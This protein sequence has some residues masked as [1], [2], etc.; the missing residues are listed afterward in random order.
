MRRTIGGLPRRQERRS[1]GRGVALAAVIAMAWTWPLRAAAPSGFSGSLRPAER[2][3]LGL[4]KLTPAELAGLDAAVE[5]YR[6]AGEAAAARDAA[7]TAVAD[8]QR[9]E[10]P[11][12]VAR[13]MAQARREQA[14][15]QT[16]RIEA[17]VVG[18]FTG[19]NGRTVF[20]LDNGQVWR[21]VDP[22][23]YY[24]SPQQ[25]TP[26]EIVRSRYGSY[27]LHLKNGA[28]VTVARLR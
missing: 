25:N 3:V 11:K 28:W 17:V 22:D 10:E 2:A 27:R 4:D 16:E 24:T 21:Q 7:Q 19:W 23:V 1:S 15:S 26:V 5:A 9:R 18:P 20:E 12:R 13:A 6:H 14:E 8:Y